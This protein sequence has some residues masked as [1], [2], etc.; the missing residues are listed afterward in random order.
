MRYRQL[1]VPNKFPRWDCNHFKDDKDCSYKF[2]DEYDHLN[3]EIK[4]TYNPLNQ[5]VFDTKTKVYDIYD[6]KMVLAVTRGYLIS[7]IFRVKMEE[8]NICDHIIYD[9]I[10]YFHNGIPKQDMNFIFFYYDLTNHIDYNRTS[11]YTLKKDQYFEWSRLGVEER[12]DY[13]FEDNI[14]VSSYNDYIKHSGYLSS[15][16]GLILKPKNIFV[17]SDTNLDI[18]AANSSLCRGIYFSERLINYISS[19]NLSGFEFKNKVFFNIYFK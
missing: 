15:S 19:S 9:N 17:K 18:L 12:K 16:K 10:K 6:L 13:I 8:F 3:L 4:P 11:F 2:Y 14:Q 5:A 1:I 7:D